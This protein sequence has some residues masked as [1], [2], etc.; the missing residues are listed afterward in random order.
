MGAFS[1]TRKAKADL[2]SIVAYTQR[3][4]GKSQRQIY[5]KQFDDVFH[6]LSNTPD[7][8][9]A[10]EYIREG[11]RKLPCSSHIIFNRNLGRDKVEIVRTLHKRMN[12]RQQMAKP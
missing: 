9:S 6:I 7:A 4:W 10:C 11:Y 3:E 2:K 1:L 5:A 12:A 8:G